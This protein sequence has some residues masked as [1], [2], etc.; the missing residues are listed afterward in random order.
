MNNYKFL[1]MRVD[2]LG[3]KKMTQ[4]ELSSHIQIDRNRIQQLETSPKVVPKE[5]ELRAY[6]QFF[7]TTADYLLGISNAKPKDED[8]AMISKTTGLSDTSIDR[9]RN[10]THLQRDIVDK[11][12]S[13]KAMDKVINAYIYRNSQFFQKIE[14]V[15]SICGRTTLSDEENSNY[16]FFQSVEMLKDAINILSNDFELFMKLNHIH[17]E[18]KSEELW[19][20]VI[21]V[22]IEQNGIDKTIDN[23]LASKAVPKHAVDYAKSL[24]EKSKGSD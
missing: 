15:D 4:D 11:L 3:R 14:I 7:N 18:T 22:Q 21:D 9:L 24:K 6:C 5:T 8:I 19:K 2:K 1:E 12:L 10:Y 16:H 20:I 17:T 13:T 23:L